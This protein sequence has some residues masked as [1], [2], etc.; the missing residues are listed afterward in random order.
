MLFEENTERRWRF[1]V[2]MTQ[3]TCEHEGTIF[4]TPNGGIKSAKRKVRCVSTVLYRPFEHEDFEPLVEIVRTLWHDDKYVPNTTFGTLEATCDLAHCLSVSTF[5]QVALID[6]TPRGIILARSEN[7]YNQYLSRWA[8][9]EAESACAMDSC[10]AEAARTFQ[11]WYDGMREVDERLLASSGLTLD[12]EITLLAVDPSAQGLG[13]GTV[14]FDAA[15]SYYAALGDRKA[16]LYT[17]SDCRWSFYE[18]HGMK[19]LGRYKS[20]REERSMLPREMY[21]YGLDLSA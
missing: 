19:R 12:N 15:S 20:T 7:D 5:S 9:I 16:Y 1:R 4:R 13:I 8:T 3:L 2:E 18:H 17:D 10:D 6:G 21:L 14:L 11:T